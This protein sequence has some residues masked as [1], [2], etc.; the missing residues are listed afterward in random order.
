[1]QKLIKLIKQVCEN[2]ILGL[3]VDYMWGQKK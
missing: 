3:E 2:R 1:M